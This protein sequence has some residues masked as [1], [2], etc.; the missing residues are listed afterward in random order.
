MC[1]ISPQQL[2]KKQALAA[3]GQGHLMRY[4]EDFLN[5]LG[6]VSAC[7]RMSVGLGGQNRQARSLTDEC[8]ALFPSHFIPHLFFFFCAQVCAQVLLTLENLSDREQ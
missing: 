6:I 1:C 7:K 3:V 2:A 5:S 8:V 4:Y